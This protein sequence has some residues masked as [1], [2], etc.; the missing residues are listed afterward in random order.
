MFLW[1]EPNSYIF[2]TKGVPVLAVGEWGALLTTVLML[3]Y[4]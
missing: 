2:C 4:I 3:L 1:V